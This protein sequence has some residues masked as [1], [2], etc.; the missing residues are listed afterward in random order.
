[1]APQC[2]RSNPVI[3][4]YRLLPW[5]SVPQDAQLCNGA[6]SN[7]RL[8]DKGRGPGAAW[9][10]KKKRQP[11]DDDREELNRELLNA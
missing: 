11:F 3:F 1:M 2:D 8:K 7:S 5:P 10:K 9:R 4:G 6:I